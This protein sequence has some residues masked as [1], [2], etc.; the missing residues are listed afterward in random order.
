LSN[1]DGTATQ[2]SAP[3][4]WSLVRAQLSRTTGKWYFRL[5]V[6]GVDGGSGWIGGIAGAAAPLNS[7]VGSSLDGAGFQTGRTFYQSGKSFGSAWSGAYE[8][9]LVDIAV[10]LDGHKIWAK[11]ERANQWNQSRDASPAAGTG[12]LDIAAIT[13]PAF[14]AWSGFNADKADAATLDVTTALSDESLAG[15]SPWG[16]TDKR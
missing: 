14:P 3:H 16:S 9:D 5:I 7:F 8:G 2:G 11:V 1:H 15:F 13:G 10:D 12:G 4:S 6:D